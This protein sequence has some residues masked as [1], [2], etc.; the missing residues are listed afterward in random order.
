MFSNNEEVQNEQRLNILAKYNQAIT[1]E[2]EEDNRRAKREEAFEQIQQ[3]HARK[4]DKEQILNN[5][6]LDFNQSLKKA[7]EETLATQT[8]TYDG[9]DTPENI[10]TLLEQRQQAYD[11]NKMD[12]V[13]K[14]T[15]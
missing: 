14:L 7:A 15:K 8:S 4:Q 3:V 1:Q 13:V 11:Q 10:L 5:I 2:E 6:I 9:I 12:E